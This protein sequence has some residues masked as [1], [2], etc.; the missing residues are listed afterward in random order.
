MPVLWW[1]SADDFINP[2]TLP[3]PQM[4]LKRMQNFRFRLLPASAE[5]TGHL[6]FL[7]TRFFAHDVAALLRRS[8]R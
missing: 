7:Q 5:T 2:P 3:Y 1:D 4:A 6:T 8:S